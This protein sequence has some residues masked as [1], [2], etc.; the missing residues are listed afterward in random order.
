MANKSKNTSLSGMKICITGVL[1]G[2]TRV[3]AKQIIE[4]CGGTLH[5]SVGPKTDMLLVGAEPGAKKVSDAKRYDVDIC[6]QAGLFA[7]IGTGV[8][9]FPHAAVPKT[10]SVTKKAVE[11]IH[12]DIVELREW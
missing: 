6:T 3:Q 12:E 4:N 10:K 8:D 1:A 11:P 2:M 5:N 9:I 7:M